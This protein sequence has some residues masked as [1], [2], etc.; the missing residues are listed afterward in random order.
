MMASSCWLSSV[1]SH[2]L[3]QL[4]LLE[5]LLL[6]GM[7]TNNNK[8][9]HWSHLQVFS[10]YRCYSFTDISRCSYFWKDLDVNCN[11]VLISPFSLPSVAFLF[12]W[13]GFFLSFCLTSSAAGRYGAISG[14][15]LSL[16]KWVLIVRVRAVKWNP[17]PPNPPQPRPAQPF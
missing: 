15:G 8:V 6:M 7:G 17:P 1:R 3:F 11:P 13:I 14:F 5:L 9:N 10:F 2:S 12:N 4:P 16:I